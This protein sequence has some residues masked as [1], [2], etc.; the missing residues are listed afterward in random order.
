M[1]LGHRLRIARLKRGYSLRELGSL[2]GISAP[3]I[4]AWET[5][6]AN[7]TFENLST[8]ADLLAISFEWLCT[9]KGD[10]DL[11]VYEEIPLFEKMSAE[12]QTTLNGIAELP[13]D[14]R[15]E[16]RRFIDRVVLKKSE[17]E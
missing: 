5:G 4:S 6:K 10:M 9:G 1:N 13:Q 11:I 12:W 2:I 17:G 15:D 16:L 14:Q 8:V 3:S 7:P